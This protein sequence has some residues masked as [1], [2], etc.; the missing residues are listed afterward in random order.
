MFA[1]FRKPTSKK[2]SYRLNLTPLESR[3]VPA[4]WHVTM[5]SS[6]PGS[7]DATITESLIVGTASVTAPTANDAV[8]LAMSGDVIVTYS[9]QTHTYT[10]NPT[11]TSGTGAAF[12]IVGSGSATVLQLE[13]LAGM[14]GAT[15]DYDYNDHTWSLNV[16]QTAASSTPTPT[17][18]PVA[19]DDGYTVAHDHPLVVYADGLLANDFDPAGAEMTA[20][21]VT[22]PT[23]GSVDYQSVDLSFTGAGAFQYTPDPLYV[24]IDTFTYKV[25]NGVYESTVATVTI[26]VTNVAPSA[27]PD[28]YTITE[29]QRITVSA[30]GDIIDPPAG[31]TGG[32]S[33][34]TASL[35]NIGPNGGWGGVS[36]YN[37]LLKNDTDTDTL[38]AVLL[39]D[40]SH[41][42]LAF[43]DDGSFVYVPNSN[44]IGTDSF[45]YRATDG[46]ADSAAVTATITVGTPTILDLD[47]RDITTGTRWM[48]EEEES[49]YGL[50][51]ST[52]SIGDILARTPLPP[53]PDSGWTLGNRELTFDGTT[54]EINGSRSGLLDLLGLEGDV[55]LSVI[56]IRDMV[57]PSLYGLTNISYTAAWVNETIRQAEYIQVILQVGPKVTF[58][59]IEFTTD[60]KLLL[61]NTQDPLS[62]KDSKRYPDV[63]VDVTQEKF[64]P[65]SQTIDTQ[66]KHT[67][68]YS[69]A[70]I[71]AGGTVTGGVNSTM[72]WLRAGYN[73]QSNVKGATVAVPLGTIPNN[74]IGAH[75]LAMSYDP[76][77]NLV[78]GG[79]QVLA[80][81]KASGLQMFATYGTPQNPDN[82]DAVKPTVVRMQIAEP[83][84]TKAF[85]KARLARL[86]I[87]QTG[88]PKPEQIVLETIRQHK[89]ELLN[90]ITGERGPTYAWWVPYYSVNK[91]PSKMLTPENYRV[92]SD[93]ISGAIFAKFADYI[94][95][96]SGTIQNKE[97]ASKSQAEAKK[98][99]EWNTVATNPARYVPVTFNGKQYLLGMWAW[100]GNPINVDTAAYNVFESTVVWSDGTKTYYFPS[101]ISP[102]VVFTNA[103]DVLSVFGSFGYGV[104][105]EDTTVPSKTRWKLLPNAVN[106]PETN[107]RDT[108]TPPR[109]LGVNLYQ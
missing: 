28:S 82:S 83:T 53:T 29:D 38:R 34:A 46:I 57:Q 35:N 75:Y 24:G 18:P 5:L 92:G 104:L 20:I 11:S 66:L 91:Y 79:R 52:I 16:A 56:A 93:C 13:D 109:P 89:F 94:Y 45:T 105:A 72:E 67:L 33:S 47:G 48:R 42:I 19:S 88:I 60:H 36:D 2:H 15:P 4:T 108:F 7:T 51:I 78:G 62:V 90:G 85:E 31:G 84:M 101:G 102:Q 37:P 86:A 76:G 58:E 27:L 77:L 32:S 68:T 98:A 43:Y 10:F 97:Y 12:R 61:D 14:P 64:A 21:L 55:I 49:A 69:T 99:V 3:D 44:F 22:A 26:N 70:G 103:D 95:G 81:I 63:E 23:H 87:A 1:R 6:N 71:P 73:L 74:F 96:V 25:T 65:F 80:G 54:L 39:T 41:G 107:Q 9:G 50:G 17:G 30:S 59:Q 40:V 100:D 106:D 8:A